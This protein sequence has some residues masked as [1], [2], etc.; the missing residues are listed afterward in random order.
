[1]WSCEATIRRSSERLAHH[2][3]SAVLHSWPAV[4]Q[5]ASVMAGSTLQ[6]AP[7]STHPLGLQPL[8]PVG[9]GVDDHLR[10]WSRHRDAATNQATSS[11][12]LTPLPDQLD[13]SRRILL[14]STRMIPPC[15]TP[16]S[17]HCSTLSPNRPTT[18]NCDV[19]SLRSCS[20]PGA[21]AKRGHTQTVALQQVPDDVEL[22]RVAISAGESDGRDVDGYCRILQALNGQ[23]ASHDSEPISPRAFDAPVEREPV[24]IQGMPES[25]DEL[26]DA[27]K[28][29]DA[30]AEPDIGS[31]SRPGT[32]LDDVGGLVDVKKRIER[33]FLAPMRNPDLQRAFGKAAGGGLVLWGPPGCGKTFLARALAGELGANFYEIGLDEVLDMWIGNS[34]KNLAAIFEFAR[35]SAPCVVFFDE[36]DAIGQKRANLR[37]G[38]GAMRNVI[39]QLPQRTGWRNEQQRRSVLPCS[40]EP[41]LGPRLCADPTRPFRPQAPRAPTRPRRTKDDLRHPSPRSAGCRQ[42]RC[43]AAGQGHRGLLRSRHPLDLRRRDRAGPRCFDHRGPH[44]SPSTTACSPRASPASDR[45]SGRGWRRPRTTP[46]SPTTTVTSTNC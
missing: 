23:P 22:L 14:R 27:W 30:P 17:P 38:G 19:T 10:T 44:R 15:P 39:N 5:V 9:G 33:S 20:T 18:S 46:R 26:V 1:M 12:R 2:H 24:S 35:R 13:D 36:L 40:H 16:S 28:Q 32:T 21:R 43:E 45:A 31:F 7:V 6:T 3:D 34:E 29:H 4:A 11:D 41:P 42:D 8:K 37:G 25:V